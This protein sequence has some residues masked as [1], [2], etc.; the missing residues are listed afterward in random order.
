MTENEKV[1][2]QSRAEVLKALAHPSRLF[3]VERL[4]EMPHCVCELTEMVGADTS[5]VSKHLSILKAAGVVEE[6]RKE[7]TTVYYR[8]S[9]DCYKLI[10]QGVELVVR[11]RLDKQRR[12]L[13]ETA[14]LTAPPSSAP[15]ARAVRRRS[16]P[17]SS[18]VG[19]P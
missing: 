14:S 13:D 10:T 4:E 8:L 5:T 16:A 19:A 11:N 17:R 15:A 18:R 6:D 12:A 2:S 9:C 7:G 1:R 3:M